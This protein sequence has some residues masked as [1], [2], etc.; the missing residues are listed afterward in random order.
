M[1]TSLAIKADRLVREFKVYQ[2]GEGF[3]EAVKS[4][5]RPVYTTKRAVDDVSFTVERGEMLGFIGPN[6]AGKST[7]IKMLTGILTPT[8][9]EVRVLNLVP[10]KDRTRYVGRIAAIF[11]QRSQLWWD[12]PLRD[13]FEAMRVLYQIPMDRYKRNLDFFDN[14]L[15]IGQFLKTPPR[16][17]SLGQRMRADIACSLLHDPEIIFLDE[18]TIGLDVVAKQGVREML[19][20]VNREKGVTVLLT[21]H[22]MGDIER[23]CKRVLI[24]AGGKLIYDG[25]LDRVKEKFGT[26]KTMQVEFEGSAEKVALEGVEVLKYEPTKQTLR[27]DNRLHPVTDVIK[28]IAD[29]HRVVDLSVRDVDIE[30][31]ARRIYSEGRA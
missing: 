16:T 11:G 15:Q 13:S 24:I 23:L 5:V 31:I 19:S 8:S 26:L 21:T 9:G 2:K 4:I 27:F 12:L 22:D 25:T 3:F 30:E 10:T 14:A 6:G 7:T 18:P 17:F 28:R 20:T 29:R 1:S